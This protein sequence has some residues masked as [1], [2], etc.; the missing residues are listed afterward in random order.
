MLTWEEFQNLAKKAHA[1]NWGH[2]V[3]YIPLVE[4]MEVNSGFSGKRFRTNFGLN[5]NQVGFGLVFRIQT[6]TFLPLT[7]M[8]T[9]SCPG[10]STKQALALWTQTT[11]AKSADRNFWRQRTL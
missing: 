10:V 8:A 3:D 5:E 9:G 2:V 1:A 6:H 7:K 4:I 11:M